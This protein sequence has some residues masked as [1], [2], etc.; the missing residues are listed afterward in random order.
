MELT[1]MFIALFTGII[2]VALILGLKFWWSKRKIKQQIAKFES[3]AKAK[4]SK[5]E[6]PLDVIPVTIQAPIKKGKNLH[7]IFNKMVTRNKK[8]QFAKI[9]K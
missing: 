5:P 9:E 1:T 7:P 3:Y 8:G 6:I 4:K 2:L